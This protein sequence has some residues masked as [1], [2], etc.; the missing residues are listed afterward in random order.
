MG[1]YAEM[2]IEREISNF[3]KY[4]N[5]FGKVKASKKKFKPNAQHDP[6]KRKKNYK[7]NYDVL[8]DSSGTFAEESQAFY[9]RDEGKPKVDFYLA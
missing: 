6:K 5:H 8:K 1:E 3:G 2:A 4:G 7:F 9:F